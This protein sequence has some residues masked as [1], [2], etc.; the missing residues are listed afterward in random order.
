MNM[1]KKRI[2]VGVGQIKETEHGVRFTAKSFSKKD[3]DSIE[4]ETKSACD[5]C[6]FKEDKV[7]CQKY[8]CCFETRADKQSVYFVEF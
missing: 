7:N 4:N 5:D 1:D 6:C 2:Y 3:L 8:D